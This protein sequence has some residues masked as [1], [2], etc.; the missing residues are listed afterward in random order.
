MNANWNEVR[1]RA[2]QPGS[3]VLTQ[4]NAERQA[5]KINNAT[6]GVSFMQS[7]DPR[8]IEFL[9]GTPAAAGVY[10]TPESAQ[11]VAAVFSCVDRIAGGVS[12]LPVKMYKVGSSREEIEKDFMVDLMNKRPCPA[13]IAASHWRRI[14]EYILL[15]GDAYTL[16]KRNRMGDI[17]ELVPL[18]WASVVVLRETLAIDSRNIYS[19]N[20][21]MTIKGYDQDD[22]LHFPGYG[23][24]GMHSCSVIS[25]GARN[26]SGNAI[27]MDEYSGRFFDGGAHPSIVLT[28]EKRWI[29]SR[30]ICCR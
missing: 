22:I 20:D 23:F 30:S 14:M 7:S 12:V 1:A 3:T 11:R 16:I 9:G 2:A 17:K 21:G 5:A 18:P 19:V 26:A 4:W 13:W 29:R 25:W 24:D 8:V 27:A 6:N 28:T 15:R 10:V